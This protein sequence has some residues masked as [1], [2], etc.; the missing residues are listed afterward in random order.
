MENLRRTGIL[1]RIAMLQI[2]FTND[3]DTLSALEATLEDTIAIFVILLGGVL[4][5]ILC[6]VAELIYFYTSRHDKN[7]VT[8]YETSSDYRYKNK[9]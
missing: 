7:L 5:A 4:V 8:S 2:P 3:D 1:K 6:L 9:V